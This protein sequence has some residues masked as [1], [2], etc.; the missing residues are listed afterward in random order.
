MNMVARAQIR[1]NLS[2]GLA[3]LVAL[4]LENEFVTAELIEETDG[5]PKDAAVSFFRL[6]QRLAP[7]GFVVYHNRGAGWWMRPA[8]RDKL[9]FALES[10]DV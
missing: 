7:H 1:Y 4:L 2:K 8:V 3:I 9:R 6:R 5:A 10:E